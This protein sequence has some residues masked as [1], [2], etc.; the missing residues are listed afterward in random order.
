MEALTRKRGKLTRKEIVLSYE[1][2]GGKNVY[3]KEGILTWM[4]VILTAREGGN[5]YW[6]RWKYWEE[7]REIIILTNGKERMLLMKNTC[8]FNKMPIKILIGNSWASW[9][10]S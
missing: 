1:Q 7:E 8:I 2:T 4:E 5:I 6:N 10:L 3:E 9:K